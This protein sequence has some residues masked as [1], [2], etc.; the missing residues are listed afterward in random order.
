MKIIHTADLHLDSSLQ[1]VKNS[2]ERRS[3]LLRAL[4]NLADFAD[5]NGVS[6]VVVAGDLFDVTPSENTVCSVAEIICASK[7]NWYVLRGNHSTL[8]PYDKLKAICP[9]VNFFGDEWTYYTLED[10]VVIC[11]RELGNNDAEQ[12]NNVRLQSD[13]FNLMTLHGDV[14]SDVYGLIDGKKISA[15]PINYLALGHRHGYAQH[16][17]G[18][19]VACYSGVLEA[20][21]FDEPWQTGFVL[22]DTSTGEHRFVAQSIRRVLT[23]TVD[24]T[25]VTSDVALENKINDVLADENA[26]NYVNLV[27]VGQLAQGLNVDLAT[28]SAE[29]KFYSLRID[30]QTK[31]CYDLQQISQEVSLRG[32]FVKLALQI[33]DEKLRNDVIRLGL[34]ALEGEL[35]CK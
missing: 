21:G 34:S 13:K 19:V 8:Q 1:R 17:F 35:K 25:G 26:R 9:K 32:E 3:E 29:E 22:I 27:L 16:K 18:K 24:V 12:W 2:N 33:N 15:L 23:F 30:D 14:D 28:K 6:A 31:P 20:R 7:A 5:N 4:R 10:N 11:G